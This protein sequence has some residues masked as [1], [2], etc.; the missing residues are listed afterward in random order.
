MRAI[1]RRS[2]TAAST[3]LAFGSLAGC[4]GAIF[5]YVRRFLFK[6]TLSVEGQQRTGWSVCELQYGRTY[7]QG[8]DGA[9]YYNLHAWGQSPFV[10]IAGNQAVFALLEAPSTTRGFQLK[11][12][13]TVL[14]QY[15]PDDVKRAD[16]ATQMQYIMDDMDGEYEIGLDRPA[17]LAFFSDPRD[18]WSMQ[19]IPS[20]GAS[21][22]GKEVHLVSATLTRTKAPVTHRL[23]ADVLPSFDGKNVKP[24]LP[25]PFDRLLPM[26][27]M[28]FSGVVPYDA[29]AQLG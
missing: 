24:P 27:Q 8:F 9:G 28:P 20:Q 29:F 15:A 6:L 16:G 17:T 19:R 23:N 10:I 12:L 2:F 22:G 14:M 5:P 4:D 1:T 11:S 21:I 3:S 7:M 25:A 26:A 13:G 18:F